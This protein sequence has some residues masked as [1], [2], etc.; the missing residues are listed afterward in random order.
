MQSKRMSL[1][2]QGR[3]A[4][5]RQMDDLLQADYQLL[6]D[7]PQEEQAVLRCHLATNNRIIHQYIQVVEQD[8]N[9]PSP[10]HRP[11][12]NSSKKKLELSILSASKEHA[13]LGDGERNRKK[14]TLTAKKTSN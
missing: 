4:V 5:R 10:L 7:H 8:Y 11:P 2:L 1:T 13:G 12:N 9:V 3:C 14:L 6:N